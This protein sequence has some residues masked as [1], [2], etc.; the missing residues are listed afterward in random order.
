MIILARLHFLLSSHRSI[1]YRCYELRLQQNVNSCYVKQDKTSNIVTLMNYK[2][3][4]VNERI[5]YVTFAYPDVQ[6]L[7]RNRLARSAVNRKVGGSNPPRGACFCGLQFEISMVPAIWTIL[8]KNLG[9]FDTW[10]HV[11]KNLWAAI[12]FFSGS[13]SSM[14]WA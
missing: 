14:P 10:V 1:L 6:P 2:R 7:W 12:R 13:T 8:P 5:D 9:N 11:T 4:E 3:W